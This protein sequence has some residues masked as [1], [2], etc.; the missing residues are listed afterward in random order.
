MKPLRILVMSVGDARENGTVNFFNKIGVVDKLIVCLPKTSEK[1]ADGYERMGAGVFI[2]DQHKYI[3]DEFEFFGF[4][5]RN[6]GGVGRQGIA[7]AVEKYGGGDT[8]LLQLDDDTA[9]LMLDKR[10]M[11]FGQLEYFAN[12]CDWF[13]ENC[14][15]FIGART[16]ATPVF[17][18]TGAFTNRKVFNN[19]IMRKGERLN[20]DGFK[21]LASDDYRFEIHR[22]LFDRV[23]F[24]SVRDVMITFKKSQGSRK[25]GNA[26]LYNSDYSWKKAYALMMTAPWFARLRCK[27]MDGRFIFLEFLEMSKFVPKILLTDENGTPVGEFSIKDDDEMV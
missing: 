24:L 6:C 14:R 13:Y 3:N 2:Y 15:I 25:D 27:M 1:F 23:A 26:P 12:I 4:K 20:F 16:G 21:A 17:A 19:F 22:C 8:I 5:P 18:D 11:S 9:S 7:E 10:K